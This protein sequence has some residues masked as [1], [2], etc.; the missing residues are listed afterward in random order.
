MG[1]WEVTTKG[2][3]IFF[4]GGEGEKRSDGGDSEN[5]KKKLIC[6]LKV[7]VEGYVT[8]LNIAVTYQTD[9]LP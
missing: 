9:R 6:T 5:T 7:Y 8:S 2:C 1:N 4:W 3:R